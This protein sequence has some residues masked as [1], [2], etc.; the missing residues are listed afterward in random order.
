MMKAMMKR[1][2]EGEGGKWSRVMRKRGGEEEEEEESTIQE[3]EQRG[4][5]HEEESPDEDYLA[6]G[7]F[8]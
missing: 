2:E 4:I 8:Y 7:F 3:E 5:F 6:E 1:G